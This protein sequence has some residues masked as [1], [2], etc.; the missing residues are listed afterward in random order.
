MYEHIDR[1]YVEE[2]ERLKNKRSHI[3]RTLLILTLLIF[4]CALAAWG[5]QA[6]FSLPKDYVLDL[7]S[8]LASGLFIILIV[9]LLIGELLPEDKKNKEDKEDDDD[10]FFHP[11]YSKFPCNIWYRKDDK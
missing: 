6:L 9:L 5:I 8:K 4:V 1:K 2:I 3:K 7:I 11:M 10:I